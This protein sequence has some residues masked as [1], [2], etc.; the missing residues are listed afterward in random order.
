MRILHLYKD[1]HPVVGGIENHIKDLAEAQVRQGHEVTVLVTRETGQ[2]RRE[3]INGVSIIRVPRWATVASTPLSIT[4]PL[5]L[6]TQN[7]DITHLHFPYPVGEVSQWLAGRGRPYVFTY[8]SDVVRQKRIL[9]LYGPLMMHILRQA[10][11]I[12]TT[13]DRYIRSSPYLS[14]ISDR[15]RVVPLAVDAGRFRNSADTSD[16]LPPSAAPTLL[17]LGRHRHYKGVDGLIRVLP[18]LEARLLIGGSGPMTRDWQAQAK[19]I[20]VAKRVWFLGDIPDADLP[21]LYASADIFVL[22]ANSR[23]EAF[24]MVLLEAMASGLPCVTTEVGSGTS[25]VVVMCHY[26]SGIGDLLRGTRRRIRSGRAA[27]ESE[28]VDIGPESSAEGRTLEEGNGRA[29]KGAR[30][31]YLQH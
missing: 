20:G 21:G 27:G 17:F 25:F 10:Q 6:R 14:Q 13:S 11:G 18:K 4:F 29:R 30:S 16:L 7:P 9:S 12:I 5:A 22:P 23:A 8:H 26:R 15:C 3:M 1:Y 28:S 19:K 31:E 24:G 2:A